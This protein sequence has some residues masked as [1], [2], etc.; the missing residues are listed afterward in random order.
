MV[1]ESVPEPSVVAN[2]QPSSE[3]PDQ[4]REFGHYR[5]VRELGRGAQ[6]VVYLAQDTQLHREVALK[7]LSGAGAM[8]QP[9]RDRFQREARLTSKFEHPG[10]CGVH[11][12][13]EVE[14]VPYIAMQY[15]RGET[16]A[17]ILKRSRGEDAGGADPAKPKT[18][19]TISVLGGSAR[20]D[21]QDVVRL[22][23]RAARALHVA[24]EAGLVHRDIKP[25]NLMVTLE[26]NPVLLDFGLARDL[27]AEGQ[28]LTQSGQIMGTPA[29]LAPEQ[30]VA[31]RGTVDRRTDVYALGVT[32]FECLTSRRPYDADTWDQLFHQILHGEPANPRS[33]NPRIP[34]D[35]CTVIEVAMERDRTRRYP[36][37]EHFADD[38]RRVRSFEPIR[39]KAA[40]PLIRLQKWAR[41]SPGLATGSAAAALLVLAVAM[42]L[43]VQATASRREFR[44]HVQRAEA[45]LGG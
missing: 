16:L 22:I 19:E 33:L 7:M 17:D 6:G 11:E 9:V 14:G 21:L 32:L 42:L 12:V 20:N 39:A 10:I 24:H 41:R 27:S 18:S 8:S 28:T 25:G 45:A 44:E 29:Y 37:A 5:I 38:L 3:V 43:I 30:I 2:G 1:N 26:G 31:A 23:E 35:L 13:G 40:G 34:R 15:V 4:V 36:T